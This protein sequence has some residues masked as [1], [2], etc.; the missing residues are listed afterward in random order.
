MV[1]C[2]VIPGAV[3]QLRAAEPLPPP[4]GLNWGDAPTLLVDWA[5]RT[6]LDQLVK[7]PADQPRLKI[8]MI[9]AAKG[10]LPGHEASTLEA[11]F[12]DGRLFE[13]AIHYTY[14]GK[15]ADFVRGQFVELKGIL[16]RRHGSFKPSGDSRERRD[17]IL[18]RSTAYRN[19]PTANRSLMLVLTEVADEKRGDAAAR[20]T[21]VYHNSGLLRD[22]GPQVIIRRDGVDLPDGP[23]GP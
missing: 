6:K 7:A 21:V 10:N 17:G 12:M 15:K 3:A 11:R 14:P 18:V 2:M 8:L 20:F 1:F 16:T 5:V 22:E 13:V 9:T 23:P 4:F 19:G